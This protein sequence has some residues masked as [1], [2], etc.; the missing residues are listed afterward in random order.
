VTS[1]KNNLLYMYI[2]DGVAEG[3]HSIHVTAGASSS[4]SSS[5]EY[6]K[7]GTIAVYAAGPPYKC[8]NKN[9]LKQFVAASTH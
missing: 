4:S 9:S 1:G 7:G 3:V 6:Y 8:H 5:N 2:N